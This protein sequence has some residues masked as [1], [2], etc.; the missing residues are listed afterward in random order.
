MGE[1]GLGEGLI[2][3]PLAIREERAWEMSGTYARSTGQR[4]RAP[5]WQCSLPPLWEVCQ[6]RDV[7]MALAQDTDQAQQGQGSTAGM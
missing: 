5:G 7:L 3:V 6:V 1:L 2:S 4:G